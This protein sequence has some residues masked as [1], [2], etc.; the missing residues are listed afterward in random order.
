[1]G[2]AERILGHAGPFYYG[3]ESTGQVEGIP[4]V[5]S[6]SIVSQKFA[7]AKINGLQTSASRVTVAASGPFGGREDETKGTAHM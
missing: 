1:M 4:R 7:V 3:Q 5:S 6:G 2:L